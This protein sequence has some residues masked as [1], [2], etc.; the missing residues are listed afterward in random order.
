MIKLTKKQYI[1][2]TAATST[3]ANAITTNNVTTFTAMT[4][5]MKVKFLGGR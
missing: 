4:K 3:I 2:A 1:N 5:V